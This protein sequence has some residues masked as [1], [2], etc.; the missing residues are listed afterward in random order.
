MWQL[1]EELD[2]VSRLIDY[3]F[4]MLHVVVVVESSSRLLRPLRAP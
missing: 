4:E 1:E 3:V 2:E